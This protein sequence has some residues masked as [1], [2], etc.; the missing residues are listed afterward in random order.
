MLLRIAAFEARYQLR[1][2]LFAVGFALFFLFT[3]GSVTVDEVQIGG[4]GNVNVNSPFAIVQTV[5]VMALLSAFIV[6]AFVAGVIVRDDETG[7]APILRATRITKRD[8]LLGRFAGAFLVAV[9]VL[10][11]VPLGML[12][13][14]WMP[15]LDPEKV[16]PFVALHYAY[17]FLVVGVPTMFVMATGFFALATVTRSMMWTYGG[18]VAFLVLF[19]VSRLLLRDPAWD[20]VAALADPFGVSPIARTTRY[21]TAADRNTMLPPL[22][23][24]MLAN[25]AIW[26]GVSAA[27]FGLAYWRF[28]FD[29]P[30]IGAGRAGKE[31]ADDE[32]APVAPGVHRRLPAPAPGGATGWRQ[33]VALTRFDMAFVFRSPAFFVLLAMGMFNAFG[34]LASTLTQRGVQYFPVT[35]S[36]VETLTGSFTFI[37]IIIAI[38]YAGE[39]VWRDHERRMHEITGASAAPDW[40]FVIPKILAIT[41]VLL[42]T[43]VAAVIVAVGFQAWNGYYDFELSPYALWFGW[44]TSSWAG[45]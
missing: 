45:R 28:R 18:L 7:F 35:R 41:F 24:L 38:Y 27:I 21:W 8:Y 16:G 9:A 22:A 42:A 20:T 30:G 12:V 34:G 43:F 6:T 14:S 1:A 25:R 3:F 29:A 17:A 31:K 26:L 39:L 2:P 10:A 37:P 19:V 32:R 40:A 23:G 11:A 15:W 36:A 44:R 33:F 4:K 5:G 13:G